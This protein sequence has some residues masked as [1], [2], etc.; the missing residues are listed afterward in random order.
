MRIGILDQTCPGWPE[1]A[2]YT[3]I[4][5]ASLALSKKGNG[6]VQALGGVDTAEDD[7]VIF[8]ARENSIEAPQAI[9]RI[10]SPLWGTRVVRPSDWTT[11]LSMW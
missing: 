11:W 1:G 6:P 10:R 2:S 3:R 5:L 8:L 7:E 4:I 9:L